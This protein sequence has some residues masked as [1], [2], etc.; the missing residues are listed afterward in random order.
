MP[1]V[2]PNSV[3][4]RQSED[5]ELQKHFD[6]ITVLYISELQFWRI[7]FRGNLK[8]F[9]E[10]MMTNIFIVNRPGGSL[11][12]CIVHKD[13]HSSKFSAPSY[14]WGCPTRIH[15]ISA[16]GDNDEELGFIFLTQN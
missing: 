12:Y 3:D 16:I 2:K 8:Y 4:N 9:P 10:E 13:V 15:S 7:L 1:L 11:R 5:M 14:E 6:A